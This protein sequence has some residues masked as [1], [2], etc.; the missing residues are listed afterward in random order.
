MVR[1]VAAR[2]CQVVAVDVAAQ[3]LAYCRDY[4]DGL[5]G[6][7]YVLCDGYGVPAVPNDS[8]DGA[9]SFYVFQH[10]PSRRMATAVIADLHRVLKPGGWCKVQTVDH[11]IDGS[12]PRVGFH[13]ERQTGAFVVEAAR[14]ASFR[15][16]CLRLETEPELDQITLTAFK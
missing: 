12:V 4:C 1:P 2:G 6:I 13:G 7:E 3:M 10:M 15:R 16:L 14:Q 5:D 11:R 8:L 9:Y